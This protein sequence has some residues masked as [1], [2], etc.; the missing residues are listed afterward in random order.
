MNKLIKILVTGL[1]TAL[2]LPACSDDK[3]DILP[4]I[5]LESG[6]HFPLNCD[7]LKIGSSFIFS[8]TFRDNRELGGWS[9]EIHHNFDHH[10]HST[11]TGNCLE[12]PDKD[13]VNPFFM[14]ESYTIPDGLSEYEAIREIIIPDD[15][16]PGDYHMMIRL[17]DK[18]GWQT[19]KG[20]SLKME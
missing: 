2:I 6:Q 7:T 16:D 11:E 10:T 14:I 18:E 1:I 19:L 20:L 17:T 13:P 4:E 8:A 12:H 3:D 5:I 15:S 9:L